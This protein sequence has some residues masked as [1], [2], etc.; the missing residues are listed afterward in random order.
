MR[1]IANDLISAQNTPRSLRRHVVLSEMDAVSIRHHGDIRAIVND[2]PDISRPRE[3]HAFESR[4][5]EL[6]GRAVLFSQLDTRRSAGDESLDLL[7]MRKAGYTCVGY[8]VN[9]WDAN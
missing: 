1:G 3:R 4:L 7:Q 5:M 2:D 8:G 9:P 6:A